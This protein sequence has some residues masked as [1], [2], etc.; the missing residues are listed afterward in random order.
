[1]VERGNRNCGSED[2]VA[3]FA[4]EMVM[5]AGVEG[6]AAK[7]DA[8]DGIELLEEGSFGFEK[9]VC[10]ERQGSCEKEEKRSQDWHRD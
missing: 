8:G 7:I 6:A 10:G 3:G 5:F 9:R 2:E 4:V 1:M